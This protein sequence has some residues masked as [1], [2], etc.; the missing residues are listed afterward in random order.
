MD[1]WLEGKTALVTGASRGLGRAIAEDLAALG[2]LVAL[3]Y[4]SND[5]AARETL[6]VIEAN[7]GK[8][9]PLKNAQGSFEAAES[10]AIELDAGLQA[11]TVGIGP[12]LTARPCWSMRSSQWQLA[13]SWVS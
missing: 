4:A 3:N 11:R 1:K 8:A 9:F 12:G 6:A 2:A 10:L 7:G 5:L 13:I